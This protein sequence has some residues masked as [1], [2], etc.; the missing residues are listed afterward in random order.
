MKRE[1]EKEGRTNGKVE[2]PS[3]SQSWALSSRVAQLP[4]AQ[5]GWNH[6]LHILHHHCLEVSVQAKKPFYIMERP[7]PALPWLLKERIP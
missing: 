3:T 4:G 1:K 7:K 2:L 5:G 6:G